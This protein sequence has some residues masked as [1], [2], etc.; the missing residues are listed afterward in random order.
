MNQIAFEAHDRLHSFY[1]KQRMHHLSIFLKGTFS[2]VKGEIELT[3][4]WWYPKEK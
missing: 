1:Q 4:F 3:M 2:Y